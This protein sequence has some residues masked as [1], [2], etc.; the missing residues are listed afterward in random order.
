[1]ITMN[2]EKCANCRFCVV[3]E[4]SV[5]GAGDGG[6]VRLKCVLTGDYIEINRCYKELHAGTRRIGAYKEGE[7]FIVEAL[8]KAEEPEVYEEMMSPS[9]WQRIKKV[10]VKGE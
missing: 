10:F 8:R 4:L 3:D 5:A 6:I 1:M 7:R 9:F 2:I